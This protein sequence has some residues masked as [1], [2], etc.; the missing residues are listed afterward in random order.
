[1]TYKVL[2]SALSVSDLDKIWDDVFKASCDFDIADNYIRGI[3]GV[4]K[5]VAKS[6]KTGIPLY[7]DNIF[8]GI[9]MVIYKKY[10]A[11]YRIGKCVVEVGRVLPGSS[12]YMQYI[13]KS[14]DI[15]LE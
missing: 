7:Y 11:F 1:M 14:M 5:Q 12:D 15:N 10:I 6:P 8:T 9:Y 4:L 13:L 2:Y 3:R